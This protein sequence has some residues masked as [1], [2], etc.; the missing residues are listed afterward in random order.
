M[1]LDFSFEE[2]NFEEEQLRLPSKE[3]ERKE[4]RIVD[5]AKLPT[6]NYRTFLAPKE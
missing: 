3:D 1:D 5:M 4:I 2:I 6:D